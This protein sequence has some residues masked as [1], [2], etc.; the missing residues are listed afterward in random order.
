[1]TD[2]ER[3]LRRLTA[4]ADQLATGVCEGSLEKNLVAFELLASMM[5]A[6]DAGIPSDEVTGALPVESWREDLVVVP[7]ALLRTLTASWMKYRSADAGVS[8]GEAFGLEGRGQG[9]RPALSAL[10]AHD[11]QA[12]YGNRVALVKR[13][14]EIAGERLSVDAAIDKAVDELIA[15]GHCVSRQTVK[16]AF[17]NR[18]GDTDG[19]RTLEEVRRRTS[20]LGK[21]LPKS[22]E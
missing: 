5:S 10:R 16:K 17:Y 21:N 12:I 4:R 8:V 15:E 14:S 9:A 18:R 22:W 11:L 13:L 7:A 2:E 6:F 3:Y 1:M 19:K 20:D